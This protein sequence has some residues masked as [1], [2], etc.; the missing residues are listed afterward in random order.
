MFACFLFFFSPVYAVVKQ[1]PVLSSTPHKEPVGKLALSVFP[2][3]TTKDNDVI[4]KYGHR[5]INLTSTSYRH[6]NQLSYAVAYCIKPQGS[7]Y[8][9]MPAGSQDK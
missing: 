3:D 1:M 6:S 9:E 4:P 8:I 2:K 5:T 7:L